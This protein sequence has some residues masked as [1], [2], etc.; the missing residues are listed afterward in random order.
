MS[1]KDQLFFLS[2]GDGSFAI[3]NDTSLFDT[4]HWTFG[5][6]AIL[7]SGDIWST[8]ADGSDTHASPSHALDLNADA[9]L[10]L[11]TMAPSF[12][13]DSVGGSITDAAGGGDGDGSTSLSAYSS[14]IPVA[15]HIDD[16]IIQINDASFMDQS[17]YQLAS[18][19]SDSG[20]GVFSTSGWFGADAAAG[21]Q[22]PSFQ[23]VDAPADNTAASFEPDLSAAAADAKS[24]S[25]PGGGSGGGHNGGGDPGLPTSYTSGD[26]NVDDAFEFNIHIEYSGSWT[27]Q[28]Q[29]IVKWAADLWSTIITADVRDDTDLNGNAVDD[30][31]ISMST[32]HTTARAIQ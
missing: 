19:S 31:V 1:T 15:D 4:P 5:D 13:L 18:L 22:A 30:I 7:S 24:G 29:A 2:N 9:S 17:Q 11:D 8:I 10:T 25:H 16:L 28:E 12:Q 21:T 26:P 20:A 32:G 6:G 3:G 14:S 23:S 27:A